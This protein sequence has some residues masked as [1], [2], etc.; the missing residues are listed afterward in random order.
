MDLVD[1]FIELKLHSFNLEKLDSKSCEA[2]H[3][4]SHK[5]ACDKEFSVLGARLI[6]TINQKSEL[7]EGELP[8][9]QL[10]A[11]FFRSPLSEEKVEIRSIKDADTVLFTQNNGKEIS[12]WQN[13]FI[14]SKEDGYDFNHEFVLAQYFHG[15]ADKDSLI[16]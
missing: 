12:L 3:I 5:V 16:A 7:V 8:S 9:T 13:V 1:D 2:V 11:V 4:S 6:T 15:Y 10:F 14:I